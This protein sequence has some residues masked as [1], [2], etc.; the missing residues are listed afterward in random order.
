MFL[1]ATAMPLP[2]QSY[3]WSR[4]QQSI[5]N[6]TLLVTG[7]TQNKLLWSDQNQPRPSQPYIGLTRRTFTSHGFD[8][9]LTA[10]VPVAA[11]L[12][13]T[14][15]AAGETSAFLVGKRKMSYTLAGADTTEI[16]RDALLDQVDEAYEP[17]IATASGTDDIDFAGK[18]SQAIRVTPIEGATVAET[19]EYRQYTQGLRRAIVRVS[20][21]GFDTS[22]DDAGDEYA[23]A[24]IGSLMTPGTPG[25]VFLR[26]NSVGVEN[27][28][29]ISAQN[30]STDLNSPSGIREHRIFFDVQFNAASRRFFP[31]NPIDAV[32]DPVVE[33]IA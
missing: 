4:L 26:Q 10:E 6:W 27:Q 22:G 25:S 30:F 21:F 2:V 16:A 14:A 13:V 24:L 33:V 29:R 20:L 3:V 15:A 12:T 31:E 19:L 11:T 32:A 18:G 23:D 17:V 9:E 5:G 28:A 8:D 7:L 1:V